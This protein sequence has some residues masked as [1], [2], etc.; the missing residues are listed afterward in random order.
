MKHGDRAQFVYLPEGCVYSVTSEDYK[1]DGYT[2]RGEVSSQSLSADANVDLIY[3][4]LRQS[5][6][7]GKGKNYTGI[8]LDA[9]AEWIN[10][11]KN[12]SYTVGV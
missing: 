3:Y 1:S 7:I 8:G 9:D 5:I 6:K 2:V 12:S 4:R 10:I 11:T